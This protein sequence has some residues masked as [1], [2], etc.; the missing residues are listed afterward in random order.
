MRFLSATGRIRTSGLPGRRTT[1]KRCR[2]TMR[3]EIC[4]LCIFPPKTGKSPLVVVTTGFFGVSRCYCTVVVKWWSENRV[5]LRCFKDDKNYDFNRYF[6]ALLLPS[7]TIAPLATS[8]D[9]YIFVR[10]TC[11]PMTS[12]IWVLL[13]SGVSVKY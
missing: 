3:R 9:K 1:T 6:L 2:P 4:W 8:S 12:A 10:E 7:A 13:A 5:T 11:K